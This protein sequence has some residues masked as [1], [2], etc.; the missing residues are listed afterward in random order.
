MNANK[1]LEAAKKRIIADYQAELD[2]E[3][4]EIHG[5]TPTLIQTSEGYNIYSCC[6]TQNEF[7]RDFLA[8]RS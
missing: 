7:V 1:I 5:T 3:P 2:N 4:C 8:N 6:E